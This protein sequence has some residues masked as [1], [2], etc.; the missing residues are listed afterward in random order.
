METK[1]DSSQATGVEPQLAPASASLPVARSQTRI[2]R[3]VPPF[4]GVVEQLRHAAWPTLKYL[5]ET[6]VHTFAFSVSANAVLAF[7]PF[8]SLLMTLALRVFHSPR[9]Y[10][11]IKGLLHAHLPIE[12]DLI[13]RNLRSAVPGHRGFQMLPLIM[14][15]VTSGGVFLPLEVALNQVWGFKKNR[16][17]LAN[18]L[19][20]LGLAFACG[21][22]ALA[23]VAVTTGNKMVLTALFFGHTHNLAFDLIFRG[24]MMLVAT[25]A[26]IAV[27]F[28]VYWLLPNG[29]VRPGQVLPAALIAGVLLE[30]GKYV[31]VLVLPLLGFRETYGYSFYVAVTLIFWGFL[32]GLLLLGGAHLSAAGRVPPQESAS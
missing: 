6:E 17:Y 3:S 21:V 12:Q 19:V 23:S 11:V 27:F 32:S 18:Q 22:L 14:L 10:E 7:F 9:M 20:S 5:T 24:A 15:L 8:M 4:R 30:I 26:S 28:L 2:L 13:I 31:Y 1:A 16:S 25:L 29:K